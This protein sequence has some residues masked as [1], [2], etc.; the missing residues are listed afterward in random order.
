M[1]KKR[2]EVKKKEDENLGRA[3]DERKE[4]MDEGQ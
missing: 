1:S 2:G 4:L 3:G